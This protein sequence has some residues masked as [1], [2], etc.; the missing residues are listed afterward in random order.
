MENK[1]LV[2]ANDILNLVDTII[3]N[4]D[5]YDIG[6]SSSERDDEL[7]FNHLSIYVSDKEYICIQYDGEKIR[8][9]NRNIDI[10][11]RQLSEI[12]KCT[13]SLKFEILNDILKQRLSDRIHE[14]ITI[15]NDD[16][17]E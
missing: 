10:F 1:S 5:K 13:L 16:I 17:D 15:P 3:S 8:L 9:N 12:E 2:T 7:K 4:V 11:I 14:L 6:F